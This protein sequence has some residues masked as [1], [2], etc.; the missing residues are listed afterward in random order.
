MLKN[1]LKLDGAQELT[2]TEQINTNGGIYTPPGCLSN[3]YAFP[4]TYCYS[5]GG[6]YD[7]N[8]RVCWITTCVGIE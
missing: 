1:I 2:K 3:A 6:Q 8:S 4:R 7:V 5:V